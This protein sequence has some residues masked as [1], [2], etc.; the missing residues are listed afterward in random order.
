VTESGGERRKAKGERRKAKGERRK[1]KGERV[2][3]VIKK[4]ITLITAPERKRD[5]LLMGMI[6]V[7]ALLD[8]LGVAWILPF[9]AVLSNPELVQ[10]V[11]DIAT[12]VL[13]SVQH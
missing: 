6:L 11:V 1:A 7:M 12:E 5:G 13:T 8:V 3:N 9:M 2:Q 4:L 10:V